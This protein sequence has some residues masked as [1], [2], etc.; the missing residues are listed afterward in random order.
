LHLMQDQKKKVRKTKNSSWHCF[1][2]V[3]IVIVRNEKTKTI[4]DHDGRSSS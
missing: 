3:Y 2:K 1:Q 4:R